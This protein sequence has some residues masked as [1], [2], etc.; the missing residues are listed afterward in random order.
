MSSAPF[1][2]LPVHWGARTRLLPCR[3]AFC[4][5]RRGEEGVTF[6]FLPAVH[7]LFGCKGAIAALLPAL[8][9]AR[10]KR[11]RAHCFSLPACRSL[12]IG[13]RDAIAAHRL[14][15]CPHRRRESSCA[16]VLSAYL[17]PCPLRRNGAT[18]ALL[19]TPLSTQGKGERCTY[20]F[21]PFPLPIGAPKRDC[22]SSIH[23]SG[24]AGKEETAVL[25]VPSGRSPCHW[26]AEHGCRP[27]ICSFIR[28]GEEE[29]GCVIC[30][31]PPAIP[32]LLEAEA[33][34]PPTARPFVR[35]VGGG[36]LCYRPSRSPSP[37]KWDAKS[38]LPR[39]RHPAALRWAG[40]SSSAF[41]A[42]LT[43]FLQKNRLRAARLVRG[44]LTAS[45]PAAANFF[46]L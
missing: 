34:L 13:S 4:L 11:E 46:L 43:S 16:A 41:P 20:S 32:C 8:L 29:S 33:R 28:A 22:H 38:R 17:S 15:F 31:F 24:C 14:P 26:G 27:V 21:P 35:T 12:S 39:L 2:P 10:G 36:R 40:D 37:A 3:P 9:S 6:S 23:S 18:T 30:P 45:A 25:S 7:C 5:H 19:P 42:F 44:G 1:P